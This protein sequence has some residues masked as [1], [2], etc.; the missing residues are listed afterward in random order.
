MRGARQ[1]RPAASVPGE[2]VPGHEFYDYEDKYLDG[3]ADHH[4]RRPSA[5]TAE[6]QRLAVEAFRALRCDGMARV[7]FFYEDRDRGLS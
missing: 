3:N 6:I 4:P 1:R 5:V 7:D 2:I